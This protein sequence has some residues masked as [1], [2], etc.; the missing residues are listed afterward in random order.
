V[1]ASALA[2][3]EGSAGPAL[4]AEATPP[5]SWT[6]FYV[7]VNAGYNWDASETRLSY[8]SDFPGET[9]NEQFVEPGHWPSSLKSDRDGFAGGVAAGANYQFGSF[10]V[11][12]EGDVNWFG[13]R[14]STTFESRRDF[15]LVPLEPG[16]FVRH[17]LH[18]TRVQAEPEWLATVRGRA[19]VA[20]DRL[21]LFVTAGVSFGDVNLSVTRT[22]FNRTIE[23]VPNGS[24]AEFSGFGSRSDIRVGGTVGGGVEYALTDNVSVKAEY[25]Y[26]NLGRETLQAEGAIETLFLA[27]STVEG[28]IGRFGVNYRF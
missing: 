17:E 22:Y 15:D 14:G 3:A 25:L 6:G 11:G 1:S 20:F 24:P 7:G 28:S 9:I 21:L 16:I 8:T 2:A 23:G 18:T 19:G 4:E 5:F 27:R 26:Y 12:V 10:V 13:N